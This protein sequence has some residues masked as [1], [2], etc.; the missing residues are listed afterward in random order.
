MAA[1]KFSSFFLLCA[2]EFTFILSVLLLLLLL[3]P[4]ESGCESDMAEG[5]DESEANSNSGEPT[6][7]LRAV[8]PCETLSPYYGHIKRE[9][10]TTTLAANDKNSNSILHHHRHHRASPTAVSL[11]SGVSETTFLIDGNI[12]LTEISVKFDVITHRTKAS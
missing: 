7:M 10:E 12:N 4:D 6:S 2:F 9:I 1:H 5:I 11:K 3:I 8:M